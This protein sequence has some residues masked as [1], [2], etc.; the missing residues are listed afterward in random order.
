MG[1]IRFFLKFGKKEHME[2]L[3]EGNLYCSNAQTFWGIEDNLK[4][5]GQGDGL[6]A[7][8]V[9]HGQ[10]YPYKELASQS[11]FDRF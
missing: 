4:I 6:E 10:L 7:S 8:T 5:R 3:V 9:V 1:N 11:D 2:S